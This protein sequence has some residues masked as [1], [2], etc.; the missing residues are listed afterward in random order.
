VRVFRSKTFFVRPDVGVPEAYPVVSSYKVIPEWFKRLSPYMAIGGGSVLT[1]GL[2]L[3]GG[4][5]NLT[6]KKC[7]PFLDALSTGYMICA[8]A[9]VQV[10]IENGEQQFKWTAFST[11]VTSH[12]PG[13]LGEFTVPETYS[14]QP[15]KWMNPWFVQTPPGYS[16]LI[17]HPLN[18]PDLPFYTFSGVIDTDS[19]DIN[20]N[21]P[22]ILKKDWEG[23][24]ERGTPLAQVFP[25]K[26]DDW[27]LE[28]G[29]A[30]EHDRHLRVHKTTIHSRY[31]KLFWS[32]K[33]YSS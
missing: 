29:L 6:V 27:K 21:L 30:Y 17:T 8:N 20:I 32:K 12:I 31:K 16:C 10:V 22:F 1:R 9:D 5:P 3:G 26:R 7:V 4:G 2:Q 33:V 18:R 13:Q 25:F 28:T 24:I 11:F 23:I 14:K 15:W 19:H